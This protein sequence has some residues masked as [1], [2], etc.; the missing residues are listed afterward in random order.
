MARRQENPNLRWTNLPA[1]R[2]EATGFNRVTALA[3]FEMP[4]VFTGLI[5]SR[6]QSER[7]EG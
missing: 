4:G 2:D 7:V 6:S 1:R 5:L 3:D